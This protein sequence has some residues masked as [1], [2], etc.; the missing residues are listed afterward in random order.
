MASAAVSSLR[1]VGTQIDVHRSTVA[2][3]SK[4]LGEF[5]PEAWVSLG[6]Q[7]FQTLLSFPRLSRERAEFRQSEEYHP[8][9]IRASC[10]CC[11]ED[12]WARSHPLAELM[13]LYKSTAT[14]GKLE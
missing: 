8:T 5:Y 1:P 3:D 12:K 9:L 14:N 7:R 10:L 13:N 11:A 4:Q 2:R 6:A